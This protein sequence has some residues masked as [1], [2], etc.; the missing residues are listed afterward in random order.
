M[1]KINKIMFAYIKVCRNQSPATPFTPLH[2]I[3]LHDQEKAYRTNLISLYIKS[4]FTHFFIARIMF[5]YFTENGLRKISK[6]RK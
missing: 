5:K 4:L 1:H 6:L 2:K 3:K